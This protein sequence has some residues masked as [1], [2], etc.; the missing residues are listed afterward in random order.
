MSRRLAPWL[1]S[2]ILV[3]FLCGLIGVVA[4]QSY[5]QNANDPQ[6][7]IA[8]DMASAFENN[9]FTDE[10][11]KSSFESF[12]PTKMSVNMETSL[13]PWIQIYDESGEV[14]E[15]SVITSD[16][17]SIPR[18]SK[19][20]FDAV[21]KGGEDRLMWQP[22]K[23]IRQ[24][25]VVTK[26]SGLKNGYI[27]AGRSLTEVEKR[28][29]GLYKMTAI[30]WVLMMILIGCGAAWNFGYFTKFTKQTKIPRA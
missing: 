23:G 21:K 13:S 16:A 5:R 8:E 12:M 1:L 7:Q 9:Q 17:Q 15:S 27:V 20:I 22:K 25:I 19:G 14:I 24:A 29:G 3:T 11:I 10:I 30:A 2:I 28:E 4:Q 6:I 26:F 18:V